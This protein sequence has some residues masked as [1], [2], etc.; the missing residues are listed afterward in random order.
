MRMWLSHK[1]YSLILTTGNIKIITVENGIR[2]YCGRKINS[3]LDYKLNNKNLRTIVAV[4]NQSRQTMVQPVAANY[5][6]YITSDFDIKKLMERVKRVLPVDTA[7]ALSMEKQFKLH[8]HLMLVLDIAGINDPDSLFVDKVIPTISNLKHVMNDGCVINLRRNQD[9]YYH[10]L[11]DSAEFEDAIERYSYLAKTNY[12]KY[13]P[14]KYQRAFSSSQIKDTKYYDLGDNNMITPI[15]NNDNQELE[16]ND[17]SSF[18]DLQ[19]KVMS[20]EIK[21]NNFK[22]RFY[23]N[24]NATQTIKWIYMVSCDYYSFKNEHALYITLD[25][26]LSSKQPYDSDWYTE[27][28]I[29]LKYLI[30]RAVVRVKGNLSDDQELSVYALVPKLQ[31]LE[32][33]LSIAVT[34][35]RQVNMD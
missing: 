18:T 27:L 11:L 34:P 31:E 2:Y 32:E 30:N 3:N 25:E 14:Q 19:M 35:Y 10:D 9:S 13:V 20:K 12:K 17:Y 16:V 5:C 22:M 8:I 4:L 6:A 15:R 7:Y 28:S 21:P 33:V 23:I 24:D 26:L 29:Q 1:K